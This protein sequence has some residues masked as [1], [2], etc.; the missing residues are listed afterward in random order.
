MPYPRLL[1]YAG[2][3]TMQGG[4]ENIFFYASFMRTYAYRTSGP[5]EAGVGGEAVGIRA[6]RL[7]RPFQTDGFIEFFGLGSRFNLGA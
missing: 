7:R 3:L 4:S 1:L 2:I 6:F 5:A